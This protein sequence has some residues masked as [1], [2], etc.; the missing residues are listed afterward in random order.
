MRCF[1][2][3]HSPP[4]YYIRTSACVIFVTQRPKGVVTILY[5][6]DIP[7]KI[8]DYHG[9]GQ[10][11]LYPIIPKSLQL[12]PSRYVVINFRLFSREKKMV[13]LIIISRFFAYKKGNSDYNIFSNTMQ[14][15]FKIATTPYNRTLTVF[16]T[17]IFGIPPIFFHQNDHKGRN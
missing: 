5:N 17:T 15:V 10:G 6:F 1:K 13:N 7:Q 14:I 11:F 8:V 16:P 9:I 4:F 12:G 2:A 3:E